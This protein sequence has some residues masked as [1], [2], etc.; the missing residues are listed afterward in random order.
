MSGSVAVRSE[1]GRPTCTSPARPVEPRDR[2][3]SAGFVAFL[4]AWGAVAL[5]LL[6]IAAH[7]TLAAEPARFWITVLGGMLSDTTLAAYAVDRPRL[8]AV[9]SLAAIV[10][11]TGLLALI[12]GILTRVARVERNVARVERTVNMRLSQA[13]AI[14]EADVLLQIAE[15]YPDQPELVDTLKQSFRDADERWS[16]MLADVYGRESA[17]RIVELMRE[18]DALQTAR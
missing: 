13:V 17:D 16:E 5:V 12:V 2:L 7:Q 6:A 8:A 4:I 14:K 9:A 11:N 1:A 18:V 15:K 3:W 10:L